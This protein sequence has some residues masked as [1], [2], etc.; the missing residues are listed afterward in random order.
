MPKT[1][2]ARDIPRKKRKTGT[3]FDLLPTDM[4]DYIRGFM[5]PV[6]VRYMREAY[7]TQIF[8][9]DDT[10][11]TGS[12]FRNMA[13]R[14]GFE[15]FST[16]Q[17]GKAIKIDEKYYL[18]VPINSYKR[19]KRKDALEISIKCTALT[20]IGKRCRHWH[21]NPEQLCSMHLK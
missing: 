10:T 13:I 7:N 20:K 18:V 14:R 6:S 19:P 8:A 12:E 16:I 3:R 5:G 15:R 21:T 11:M 1:K 9:T 4:I 2:R 17:H